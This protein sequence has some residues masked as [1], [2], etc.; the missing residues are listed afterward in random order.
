[1]ITKELQLAIS[2]VAQTLLNYLN[3]VKLSN[4]TLQNENPLLQDHI[5]KLEQQLGTLTGKKSSLTLS[6]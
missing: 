5:E 3:Q 6:L 1:L 2:T 4:S